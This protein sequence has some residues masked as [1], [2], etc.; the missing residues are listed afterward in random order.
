[1]IPYLN[2]YILSNVIINS[3]DA[4]EKW[5]SHRTSEKIIVDENN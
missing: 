2:K 3:L 4:V 1:M 5:K